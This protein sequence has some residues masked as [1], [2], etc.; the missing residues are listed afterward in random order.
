MR[1]DHRRILLGFAVIAAL[2]LGVAARSS[3]SPELEPVHCEEL[4]AIAANAPG[5][6]V[7]RGWL[8][9]SADDLTDVELTAP[10]DSFPATILLGPGREA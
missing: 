4:T 9:V 5:S 10:P 8:C 2:S 7:I 3:A 1:R 6:P